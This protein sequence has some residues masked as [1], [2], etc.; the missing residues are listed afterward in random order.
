MEHTSTKIEYLVTDLI[1][2]ILSQLHPGSHLDS[3]KFHAS[4]ALKKSKI[5]LVVLFNLLP[6]GSS[7]PE[8]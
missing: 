4:V 8:T 7:R 3:I 2:E 1:P 6:L 5:A